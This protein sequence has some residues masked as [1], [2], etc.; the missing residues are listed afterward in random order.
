MIE[1]LG[2]V[3]MVHALAT[4]PQLTAAGAP[5]A[6][7]TAQITVFVQQILHGRVTAQPSR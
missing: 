3:I 7:T 2:G 4:P 1:A 6:D 5:D